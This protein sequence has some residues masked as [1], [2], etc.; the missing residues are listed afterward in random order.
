MTYGINGCTIHIS[1]IREN[2][3]RC[4]LT[5]GGPVKNDS[6]MVEPYVFG[7][8]YDENARRE[9]CAE[10]AGGGIAWKR[11]GREL[12]RLAGCGMEA[13]D[14]VKYTTSGEAPRIAVSKTAD[15]DRTRVSNL[16]PYVDRK[17]YAG[18][19]SFLIPGDTG[20]FGLGQDEDGFYNRRGTKYYLYQHNMRTPMPFMMTDKGWGV[21][22]DCPALMI[23]DDTGAETVI[24]FDTADQ[25]DFYVITGSMDAVVAGFRFLTGNAAMPPKWAF[26]YM[27][28]RERYRTQDEIIAVAKRY[29]ELGVPLDCVIQDWKSWPGEQWGQK[30]V[31]KERFPDLKEM[32]RILHGMNIH[33]M[34]SIWPNMAAGCPDHREMAENGCLLGDYSTYDAF[35]EKARELYWRQAKRELFDGGFDAWWCDSSEPFSA[36][37]WRGEQ[38]LAEERRFELVG[39]E[40]KKFLDPARANFYSVMHAKGIY[41]NQRRDDGS[42][43]VL[44]LTRS[45]YPGIQK[46]GAVLWGGDTPARWEAL[47]NEIPRGLNMCMSGI[48][49][50][51]VDI[52]A[53]FTGGVDCWRNWSGERDAASAWFF[54]GEYDRGVDDPAYCELFTRW[55]QL[56]AFLPIFRVHGSGTPREIWN[57]GEPGGMFYDAIER[58]IRL[59]YSLLPYIYS[60]AARVAFDGYTILRSLLFDFPEDKMSP[61]ISDEFMFGD[62]ILV[63]PVTEPMYFDHSGAIESDKTRPCYLPNGADWYDFWTG[64]LYAG[65]QT[66]QSRAEIDKIPLFVRAGSILPTQ[67]SVQSAMERADRLDV[68]IYGG[69]D[70]ERLYYDD[71]GVSYDYEKG[72]YKQIRFVWDDRAKRLT[73]R[74]SGEF[75]TGAISMM[76]HYN[77]RSK[78][79]VFAGQEQKIAF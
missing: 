20:I 53:F 4:A 60:I 67:G 2:I 73:V 18:S 26:G 56:G 55:L 58:F 44:N 77:G 42:K 43:R 34:I 14:V 54:N 29:R 16:R 62:A 61:G 47:K 22:F 52:G 27:Q 69:R 75:D 36:P 33:T 13:V 79:T 19:L 59:R 1:H 17:A 40:H 45:G 71:D 38:K 3:L 65:G 74:G 78:D 25:L 63:C 10:A 49:Y 5:K 28:C 7:S 41:E 66:V 30:T 68:W 9:L 32:H 39:G 72:V 46:Y 11:A 8:L 70:S 51:T 24:S 64:E 57:F 12:M 21:L 37:D 15:G 76:I 23:F 6:L 48:P 50:W 31:D 35:E